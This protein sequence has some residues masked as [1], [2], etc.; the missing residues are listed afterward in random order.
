MTST[1]KLSYSKMYYA[2]MKAKE[3]GISIEEY[4]TTKGGAVGGMK[5]VEKKSVAHLPYSAAFALV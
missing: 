3:L 1:T 5:I 4:L 2:K